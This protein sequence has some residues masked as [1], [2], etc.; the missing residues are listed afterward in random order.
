[1]V[2]PVLLPNA[3]TLPAPPRCTAPAGWMYCVMATAGV[4]LLECQQR[5]AEAVRR[6]EQLLGGW[7]AG[8]LAG[9][10]RHGRWHG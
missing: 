9:R 10:A 1:M 5:H 6:L 4:S 8:R 3:V 2:R 7:M